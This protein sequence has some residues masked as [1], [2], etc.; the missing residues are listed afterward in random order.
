M[1]FENLVIDAVDP[2]LVGRF[3]EAA[4]GGQHLS[5][6]PE[7]YEIELMQRGRAGAQY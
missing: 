3:W 1:Y 7:G 5:H 2:A 6:A 4:I